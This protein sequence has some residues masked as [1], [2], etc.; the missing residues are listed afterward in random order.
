MCFE[1]SCLDLHPT[2]VNTDTY[3]KID[4]IHVA[5]S[6]IK[7]SGDFYNAALITRNRPSLIAEKGCKYNALTCTPAMQQRMRSEMKHGK[8]KK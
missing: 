3:L 4:N 7:P 6:A 2:D 1:L 5:F 8:V